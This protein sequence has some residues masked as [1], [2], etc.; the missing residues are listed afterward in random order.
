VRLSHTRW[1]F[2]DGIHRVV[3]T[4]LVVSRGTG[5]TLVPFRL[6]ARP[7]ASLLRLTAG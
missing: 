3:D 6:L 5:T 1:R 2:L 4:T 7:E